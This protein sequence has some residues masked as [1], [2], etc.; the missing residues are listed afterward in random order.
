MADIGMQPTREHA[1]CAEVLETLPIEIAVLDADGAIIYFNQAWKRFANENGSGDPLAYLGWNYK[2]VCAVAAER[3]DECAA[4]ALA[5][6]E[7]VCRGERSLFVLEYPCHCEARQRWF[8]LRAC[9]LEGAPLR[10]LV[11]HDDI[12]ERKLSELALQETENKLQHVLHTLPVG[13]WVMDR[14]GTIVQGNPAGQRIWAGARWVGPEQFGE[15]KGWRVSTGEPIAAEEWA[16]AR[17]ISR[18]EISIDEE[19]EIECFD[20]THK[21]ILNSAMPLL[22]PDGE[23]S[24]AIIVNQDIT[25]RKQNENALLLAKRE[26]ETANR[27]MEN[28]LA[29]EQ[30]LSRTDGLTGVYNRRHFRELAVRELLRSDRYELPVSI[31][32]FDIDHFKSINDQ[33]GHEAGDEVL[34]KVAGISASHLRSYDILARYGGEEFIILAPSTAADGAM[35]MAE[36]IR[37]DLEE[38]DIARGM[39]VTISAGVAVIPE[40]P[41]DLDAMV[42][43]ADKALYE[44]K[45]RGRNRVELSTND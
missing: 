7:T 37:R 44:A 20:G 12:T 5:G 11:A 10:V 16:A 34:V 42:R 2:E 1:L 43:A 38:A 19:I 8:L 28:A 15:Y 4:S 40:P 13:V 18:G 9:T 39:T 33:L 25:G 21:V 45:K 41:Y 14:N 27:E 24:G 6:I 23:I 3:G 22:D 30:E 26:I 35:L 31:I 17:A 32:L 29:R 36:R